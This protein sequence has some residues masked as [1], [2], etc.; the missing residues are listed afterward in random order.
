MKK[1]RKVE[2]KGLGRLLLSRDIE[3]GDAPAETRFLGRNGY[4]QCMGLHVAVFENVIEIRPITSKGQPASCYIQI[5]NTRDA[6]ALADYLRR[7]R[8]FCD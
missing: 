2:D 6:K 4:G 7:A 3:F 5:P 1:Q 8:E